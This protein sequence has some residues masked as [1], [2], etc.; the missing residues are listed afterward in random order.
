MAEQLRGPC[1]PGWLQEAE[2]P[3]TW[4]TPLGRLCEWV[5][6]F[7]LWVLALCV[8]GIGAE[9]YPVWDCHKDTLSADSEPNLYTRKELEVR[10]FQRAQA[11]NTVYGKAIKMTIREPPQKRGGK[12]EGSHFSRVQEGWQQRWSGE[13]FQQPASHQQNLA[14]PGRLWEEQGLHPQVQ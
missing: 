5:T 3:T 6:Y 11:Q 8:S 13:P 10:S 1:I 2:P 14:F 9:P 7:A 12:S 4:N